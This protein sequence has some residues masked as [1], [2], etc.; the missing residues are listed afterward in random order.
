MYEA[1]FS[2]LKR[3]NPEFTHHLGM[4]VVRLAGTPLGALRLR[5][6]GPHFHVPKAQRMESSD[7]HG[8]LI[9]TCS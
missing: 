6:N 1:L 9:E 4:L 7:S 3:L 2:V 5:G 8:I